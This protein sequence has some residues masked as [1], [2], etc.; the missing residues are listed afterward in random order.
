MFMY[1]WIFPAYIFIYSFIYVFVYFIISTYLYSYRFIHI[2]VRNAH[3]HIKYIYWYILI[4]EFQAL[5]LN[6]W[7]R[8]ETAICCGSKFVSWTWPEMKIYYCF[9]I[10]KYNARRL[11]LHSL[12]EATLYSILVLADRLRWLT[13]SSGFVRSA[14]RPYSIAYIH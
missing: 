8:S 11:L 10:R 5:A 1:I 9:M 3:I 4:T 7:H 13:I 2:Y 12:C 14:H 6:I